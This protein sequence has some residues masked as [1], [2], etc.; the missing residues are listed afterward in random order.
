MKYYFLF[1]AAFGRPPP[2]CRNVRPNNLQVR[3]GAAV[4]LRR[5]RRALL[6]R[7]ADRLREASIGER[8]TD[9]FF[10]GPDAMAKGNFILA[11]TPALV[12]ALRELLSH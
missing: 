5:D 2:V 3:P 12:P 7:V 1:A 10:G 6:E 9:D 4:Q 11:A 8:T